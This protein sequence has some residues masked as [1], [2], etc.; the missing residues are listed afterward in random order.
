MSFS[1]KEQKERQA[2][3]DALCLNKVEQK[4]LTEY[5]RQE[6]NI[7]QQQKKDTR[8]LAWSSFT[9]VGLLS[10]IGAVNTVKN[11]QNCF[12][13][14][15]RINEIANERDS[16]RQRAQERFEKVNGICAEKLVDKQIGG[17]CYA[18]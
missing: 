8:K 2:M 14:Q 4:Q 6:Q 7:R 10:P 12:Q 18:Y 16:L 11:A 9:G 13:R 3:V 1:A 17:E 15:D 5:D